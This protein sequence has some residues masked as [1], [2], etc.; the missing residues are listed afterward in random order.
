MPRR[1]ARSARAPW[2]RN[3]TPEPAVS[4]E[5]PPRAGV[6]AGGPMPRQR[7]SAAGL[8]WLRGTVLLGGPLAVAAE[9]GATRCRLAVAAEHGAPRCRLA[10]AAEHGAPRC[11]LAVPAQRL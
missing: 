4:A 3:P 1:P 2:T 7:Y 5:S 6:A 8:R 11:R 9:H 10:V